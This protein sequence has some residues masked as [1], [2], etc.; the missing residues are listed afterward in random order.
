M[1]AG[2]L[3][4]GCKEKPYRR[5]GGGERER[6]RDGDEPRMIIDIKDKCIN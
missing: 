1:A 3:N 2:S 5:E 6:E 4:D